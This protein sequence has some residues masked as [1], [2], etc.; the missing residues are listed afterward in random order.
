MATLKTPGSGLSGWEYTDEELVTGKLGGI[1]I[2]CKGRVGPRSQ[3][4]WEILLENGP[5]GVRAV[6]QLYLDHWRG[7]R[8]YDL[9]GYAGE[10][11]IDPERVLPPLEDWERELAEK[12]EREGVQDGGDTRPPEDEPLARR[13]FEKILPEDTRMVL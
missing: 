9:V 5:A 2:A 6:A 10:E 11:A 4:E 13:Y 7:E 1:D 8:K 12:W 3:F